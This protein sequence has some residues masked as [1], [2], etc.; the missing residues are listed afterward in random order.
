MKVL[1][2]NF[3]VLAV[4][5]CMLSDLADILSPDTVMKLDDE[6]VSAIAAES[7]ESKLERQRTST[8]LKN[9]EEGLVS[10]NRFNRLRSAAAIKD[11]NCVVPE[12]VVTPENGA[13]SNEGSEDDR[14]ENEIIEESLPKTVTEIPYGW[15][16]AKKE[17]AI[18]VPE[19][20]FSIPHEEP[21][22]QVDEGDDMLYL[23][24]FGGT[25]KSK[26]GKKKA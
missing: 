11:E 7:E 26:K 2:D 12:N 20:S 14:V 18:E 8:A 16:E 1:V 22:A 10:L 9:L 23:G 5:K 25:A 21:V 19:E 17:P 13:T 4:E 15:E 24:S 6:M 3:S